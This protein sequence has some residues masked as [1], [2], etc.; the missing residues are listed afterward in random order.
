[1]DSKIPDWLSVEQLVDAGEHRALYPY[2]LLGNIRSAS[3]CRTCALNE[4]EAFEEEFGRDLVQPLYNLLWRLNTIGDIFT[5]HTSV[6][7]LDRKSPFEWAKAFIGSSMLIMT[8]DQQGR[9]SL[10][11][12]QGRAGMLARVLAGSKVVPTDTTGWQIRLFP[13]TVNL[14]YQTG[15]GTPDG[16]IIIPQGNEERT[17]FAHEIVITGS[18][19]NRRRA[20]ERWA[21]AITFVCETLE[22]L[23]EHA[24]YQ[25]FEILNGKRVVPGTR[26]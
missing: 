19:G 18:A 2:P 11:A 13:T 14:A 8:R 17:G 21:R 20:A 10:Q 24:P 25:H 23:P 5:S 15:L 6:S 1:M 12:A 16:N 26:G 3:E 4:T 7:P 22:H 9:H